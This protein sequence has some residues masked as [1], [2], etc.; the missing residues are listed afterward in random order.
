MRQRITTAGMFLLLWAAGCGSPPPP[1]E[2]NVPVPS[3]SK[4]VQP[5]VSKPDRN[6]LVTMLQPVVKNLAADDPFRVALHWASEK[7]P[8]RRGSHPGAFRTSATVESMTFHLGTPQGQ[9]LQLQ[10]KPGPKDQ[11]SSMDFGQLPTFLL[12]L[13]AEGVQGAHEGKW[14]WAKEE[15]LDRTR[16]GEYTV[17]ITGSIIRDKAEP[18]LF[19][20]ESVTLR[21]DPERRSQASVEVLARRALKKQVSQLDPKAT[22][23]IRDDQ[24]GNWLVSFHVSGPTWRY[25]EYTVAVKPDG[26]LAGIS[27]R[28]VSTCIAR[29]TLIATESGPRPI[30]EVRVGDQVWGFNTQASRRL[31]TR[32]RLI[33]V[34]E[35]TET[36]CFGKTLRVTPEHPLWTGRWVS[37]GLVGENDS[38][39]DLQLQPVA[40]GK[41][42]RL[43]ER[44]TVYDLTVD[45]PHC[46]FAGGFL[47]HNKDRA[48]SPQLDDPWY[49]CWPEHL[50]AQKTE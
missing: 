47:V 42:R 15:K 30:E 43:H 2:K 1:I 13:T 35:A 40:A 41:P 50:P 21:V 10:V 45:E 37:A 33:R 18:I 44:V 16:P 7:G 14:T 26:S 27:S 29:G 39:L 6:G 28:E 36:L 12:T 20:S 9:K 22:P 19:A 24:D 31:L 17:R 11:H 49:A 25:T 38:L 5:A 46:F 32:V 48:F 34:A 8:L 4:P 23:L 3:E